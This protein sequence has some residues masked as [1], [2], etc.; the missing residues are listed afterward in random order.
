MNKERFLHTSLVRKLGILDELSGSRKTASNATREVHRNSLTFRF[1][2]GYPELVGLVRRGAIGV[3]SDVEVRV[4]ADAIEYAY[5]DGREAGRSY[6][7]YFEGV[8]GVNV[9]LLR[10]ILDDAT[11]ISEA[12]IRNINKIDQSLF[13]VAEMTRDA[14]G[15]RECY[16]RAFARH[17]INL[18]FS[19]EPM[20]KL[21]SIVGFPRKRQEISS[22]EDLRI[23][24]VEFFTT[25]WPLFGPRVLS[26]IFR[27][28]QYR[29]KI[30]SRVMEED[31]RVL[32]MFGFERL[33]S[34][35]ILLRAVNGDKVSRAFFNQPDVS[36]AAGLS[37]KVLHGAKKFL[38]GDPSELKAIELLTDDNPIENAILLSI[39][40]M[41]RTDEI[42]FISRLMTAYDLDPSI[43]YVLDWE[44]VYEDIRNLRHLQKP[45]LIFMAS[46]ATQPS[47]MASSSSIAGQYGHGGA[48]SDLRRVARYHRDKMNGTRST[49]LSSFD[50]LPR[51]A[52][53]LVIYFLFSGGMLDR[54]ANEFPSN[55]SSAAALVPSSPAVRSLE[56]R[57]DLISYARKRKIFPQSYA[58]FLLEDVRDKYRQIRFESDEDGGRIRIRQSE[59]SAEIYVWLKPRINVVALPKNRKNASYFERRLEA[60]S[61]LLAPALTEFLCFSPKNRNSKNRFSFNNLLADKL[62]HNFLSIRISEKLQPI[63]DEYEVDSVRAREISECVESYI[64]TFSGRWLTIDPNRSFFANLSQVLA[65]IIIRES[66]VVQSREETVANL[67]DGV[68]RHSIESFDNLLDR[69]REAW[70]GEYLERVKSDVRETSEELGL[71]ELIA[72]RLMEG[73]DQG[74]EESSRWMRVNQD[75]RPSAVRIRDLLLSETFLL[76]KQPSFREN[77]K[78]DIFQHTKQGGRQSTEKELVVGGEFLAPIVALVDN[79]IPNATKSSFLGVSTPMRVRCLLE[80][81]VLRLDFANRIDSA[82]SDEVLKNVKRA[83]EL[84]EQPIE[85]EALGSSGGGTG[86]FRI[87]RACEDEFGAAFEMSISV[88]FSDEYPVVVSCRMPCSNAEWE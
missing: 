30:S 3:S 67:A 80:N 12:E 81:G 24:A 39:H 66:Y 19:K 84:I 37:S 74:F 51:S 35:L 40:V 83:R 9:D 52:V 11:Q 82:K 42:N 20:D 53:E 15:V 14:S 50:R 44:A 46:L 17:A 85:E 62:R 55:T 16:E 59:L 69:C 45:E 2:K 54:I 57:D 88:D 76:K 22:L 58:N 47:V 4:L 75:A 61:S 21:L 7:E 41:E 49:F 27:Y 70:T 32:S 34:R 25:L 86:I 1:L 33:L 13:K 79:L 43:S 65:E 5:Q 26:I 64:K 56:A 72:D 18:P 36:H 68:A 29:S 63:F 6:I 71:S 31:W 28:F 77:F 48:G 10:K 38:S 73:L 78:V 87:R 60:R 23:F 8:E